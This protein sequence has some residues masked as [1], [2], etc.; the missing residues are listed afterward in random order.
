MLKSIFDIIP[1]SYRRRGLWVVAT[2]FVRAILNFVGVA[3][4]VPILML[5]LKPQSSAHVFDR[6]SEVLGLDNHL[7]VTA[8]VCAIVLAVVIAKNLIVVLLHR[9]ERSFIFSFYK[10]VSQKLFLSYYERGLSYVKQ[11][12]SSHIARNINTAGLLFATGVLRPIAAI[13]GEALLLILVL[14]AIAVYAPVAALLT[15]VIFLPIASIFYFAIRR[16]LHNIGVDENETQRHKSRIVSETFR[17]YADIEIGG[18]KHLMLSMFSDDVSKISDL[19]ERHATLSQLPQILIEIGVVVGMIL[20]IV[21]GIDRGEDMALM[22]GVFAIAA[23]RLI[24]SVRNILTQWSLIKYN[25]YTLD[26]LLDANV[27][28]NIASEDSIHERIG[29]QN[30]VEFKDV[31]F[32]FDDAEHPTIDHLSLTI[33]RGEHVGIC[34]ASGV[35]KTTLFNLILGLYRPTSGKIEIDGEELNQYNIRKWQNSVGYVSQNVFI[36]DSTLA[37]NIALGVPKDRID[38]GLVNKVIELSNLREFVDSLKDGLETRIGEQGSR[39][40]GGQRQRIGIARALYK[41]CDILLFDEA[42]SSLDNAAEESI[43]EA[44]A[45]LR[46]DNRDLTIV[47]IAHRQT[48]LDNCNR[49]IKLE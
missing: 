36:A 27:C 29:L 33:S 2:I 17:G 39:L 32:Q 22:F 18:A 31:S 10:D 30:C 48:T 49:I 45:M 21:C 20:I 38:Y 42:T 40:S 34:G 28:E 5:T 15:L 35:G 47:M 26:I 6:I 1:K 11:H 44:L 37:E 25:R 4:F 24:P 46:S 3:M 16:Q 19:R 8:V 7:E 9:Y 13:I 14:I 41:R 43:N 23:I 12:N